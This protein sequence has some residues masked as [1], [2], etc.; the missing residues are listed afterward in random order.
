MAVAFVLSPLCAGSSAEVRHY[1]LLSKAHH[2]PGHGQRDD[3]LLQPFRVDLKVL[4][5][6]DGC[7]PARRCEVKEQPV[8]VRHVNFSYSDIRDA[9][10]VSH[11]SMNGKQHDNMIT[12]EMKASRK[13]VAASAAPKA[14][15][16]NG[17]HSPDLASNRIHV[18]PLPCILRAIDLESRDSSDYSVK[19]IPQARRK[20][21]K[22][23]E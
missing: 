12:S 8:P 7:C 6:L 4:Q 11:E 23:K 19:K 14:R 18:L 5:H 13:N 20:M 16:A 21:E 1:D 15:P 3:F 22:E 10:D 17:K 2:L 9:I